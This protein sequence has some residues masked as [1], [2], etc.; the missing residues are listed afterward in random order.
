MASQSSTTTTSTGERESMVV[1]YDS[2]AIMI[3]VHQT[4]IQ[5]P[6]HHTLEEFLVLHVLLWGVVIDCV[7]APTSC[8]GH[9]VPPVCA[10]QLTRRHASQSFGGHAQLRRTPQRVFGPGSSLF[11]ILA[12][13]RHTASRVASENSNTRTCLDIM[14]Q[15]RNKSVYIKNPHHNNECLSDGGKRGA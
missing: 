4:V 7:R 12:R 14:I 6:H 3:N 1:L 11:E 8:R 13:M 10:V 5:N 9:T 15:S 2:S